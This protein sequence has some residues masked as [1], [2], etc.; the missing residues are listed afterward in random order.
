[1]FT[2]NQNEQGDWLK[3][4]VGQFADRRAW[5]ERGV[6]G[7]LTRG[8][9]TPMHTM[10]S[11]SN[12]KVTTNCYEKKCPLVMTKN[13]K[14]SLKQFVPITCTLEKRVFAAATFQGLWV[15]YF[16]SK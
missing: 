12:L 16:Q 14:H 4:W 10:S 5:Q 2:K 9:D 8:V 1:M 11:Q 13:K 15:V 6:G 7:F 3:W